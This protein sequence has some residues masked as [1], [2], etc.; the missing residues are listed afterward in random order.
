MATY[1]AIQGYVKTN[2]GFVPK[3]CWIAHAKEVCGI[4][5]KVASNR[6]SKDSRV[7]PCPSE[8]LDA[9]KAAFAH[10]KMT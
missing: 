8:K 7:V 2:Y 1:K 10:F 3:T 5:V 6:Y 4:P 9:I